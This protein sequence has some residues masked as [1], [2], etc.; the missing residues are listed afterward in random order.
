[1]KEEQHIQDI[2]S[3]IRELPPEVDLAGIERFVLAQPVTAFQPPPGGDGGTSS[4][5]LTIKNTIVMISAISIIGSVALFIAGGNDKPVAK[6]APIQQPVYADTA[7]AAAE[8]PVADSTPAKP[9]APKTNL[10]TVYLFDP[11]LTDSAPPLNEIMIG[12]GMHAPNV[13]LVVLSKSNNTAPVSIQIA[14][15]ECDDEN[16]VVSTFVKELE[17]DG[18]LNPQRYQ[19]SFRKGKLTVGGKKVSDKLY[20]KY[21]Q[22]YEKLMGK[23][24]NAGTGIVVS[25]SKGSCSIS[26]SESDGP[27]VAE[28]VAPQAPAP[29]PDPVAPLAPRLPVSGPFV[30]GEFSQ[31]EVRGSA[32]VKIRAGS[33]FNVNSRRGSEENP[34]VT[35]KDGRLTVSQPSTEGEVEI[36]MPADHLKSVVVS[37]SG[38]ATLA[39]RFGGVSK[40]DVAGSGD[41]IIEKGIETSELTITV[42]GSGTVT[43]SG[44]Q[45]QQLKGIVMGS[46]DI[47]ASGNSS[48]VNTVISGSGDI[49]MKNLHAGTAD[50]EILGSGTL[51]IDVSTALSVRISGSGDVLYTGNPTVNK[52]IAGS[53]DVVRQ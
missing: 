50:C 16:H 41:I 32:H 14:K 33:S 15:G 18:L 1:M 42:S 22:I 10:A 39:D 25:Y 24:L 12:P 28:P 43:A 40:L 19:L 6:P 8:P 48:S 27:D 53:G 51:R 7:P 23:E 38:Q 2:F 3:Q 9:G 36:T 13:P 31:I 26:L 37:G 35:I 46:G 30:L 34:Q 47:I 11:S 29:V 49:N 4:G 17:K 21:E 20:P 52:K 45:T 5:L 44:L